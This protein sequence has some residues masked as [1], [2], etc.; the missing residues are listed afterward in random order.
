MKYII[1]LDQS[2]A[3]DQSNA[4]GIRQAAACS[5]Y[6]EVISRLS[7]PMDM[8]KHDPEDDLCQCDCLCP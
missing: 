6:P 1:A 4:S 2:T 7:S 8:W 5:V 3:G